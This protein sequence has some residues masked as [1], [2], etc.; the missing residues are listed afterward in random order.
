MEKLLGSPINDYPFW[1]S[2]N[3]FEQKAKDP[4][5]NPG[6]VSQIF[7]FLFGEAKIFLSIW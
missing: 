6:G 3:T 4:G 1:F 5:S 7:L 2:G